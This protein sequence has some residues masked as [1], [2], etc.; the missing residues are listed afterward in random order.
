LATI[1]SGDDRDFLSVLAETKVN[2]LMMD[3]DGDTA[4]GAAPRSDRFTL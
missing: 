3:F 4:E 1:Q 2:R